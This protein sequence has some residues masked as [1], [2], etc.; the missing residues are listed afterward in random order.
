MAVVLMAVGGWLA[1]S[2]AIVVGA[3]VGKFG[4][5]GKPR[6]ILGH[7][8]SLAGLGVFILWFGWFGFNAGSTTTGDGSIGRIAV[9]TNLSAA[10]GAVSAMFAAWALFRKPDASMALNGAL[11]GLVGITAGC[12]TVSPAGSMVIG[13]VSGVLV[14]LS[15][16]FIERVLKIDDPVGAVSVHCVCGAWGTLACGLFNLDGGLF[17][18]GTAGQ[19]VTQGVGVLDLP[20]C[21]RIRTGESGVAAIG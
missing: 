8:I 12:A 9:T 7:N 13:L 11:A 3:R 21:I 20:E 17:Y 1:L 15:V 14:V 18:G 16:L 19:L 5:D 4:P 6:A 10:A 2:G